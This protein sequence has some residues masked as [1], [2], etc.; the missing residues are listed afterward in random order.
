MTDLSRTLTAAVLPNAANVDGSGVGTGWLA[1]GFVKL[2][3]YSVAVQQRLE[4]HAVRG[5]A[6]FMAS[7][8][9]NARRLISPGAAPVPTPFTS[10]PMGTTPATSRAHREP[11]LAVT[12]VCR[13]APHRIYLVITARGTALRQGRPVRLQRVRAGTWHTVAMRRAGA[14]RAARF[15][16]SVRPSGTASFRVRAPATAAATRL[17]SAPIVLT[18]S[19]CRSEVRSPAAWSRPLYPDV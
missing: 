7:M 8:A 17:T 11:R 3:R 16:A 2:G 15:T 18:I 6:Q 10:T 12:V 13:V 9:V 5:Q 1:D 14:H 19:S 4:Q